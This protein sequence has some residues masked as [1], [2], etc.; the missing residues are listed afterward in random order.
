MTS[1]SGSTSILP[2]IQ[3]FLG[4]IS[5]AVHEATVTLLVEAMGG[6]LLIAMLVALLTFSTKSSRRAPIFIVSVVILC[7]GMANAIFAVYLIVRLFW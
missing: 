6:T 7:A 1:I 5:S 3:P 2:A 4:L